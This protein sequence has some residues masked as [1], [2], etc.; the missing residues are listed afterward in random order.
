M[1]LWALLLIRYS[2]TPTPPQQSGCAQIL[3]THSWGCTCEVHCA[4]PIPTWLRLTWYRAI[5]SCHSH[6]EASSGC[7]KVSNLPWMP[8]RSVDKCNCAPKRTTT[9]TVVHAV[10]HAVTVAAR[11]CYTCM[12]GNLQATIHHPG[13]PSLSGP[14]N[15]MYLSVDTASSSQPLGVLGNGLEKG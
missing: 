6:E 9:V 5:N 2:K 13:V 14:V 4:I 8:F 10:G 1:I 15:H 3:S 11:H 12:Q 7:S